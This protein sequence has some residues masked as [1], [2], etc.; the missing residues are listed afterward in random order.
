MRH[1][2]GLG[3]HCGLRGRAAARRT[4]VP[5]S[6]TRTG[7]RVDQGYGLTEAAGV[8]TTV[9]GEVLGHG[10][11]GRPLPGVEVR[12]GTEGD[13]DEPAEIFAARGQPLLR[14]LARRLRWPGRRRVVRHRRHR[15]SELRRAVPGRPRPGADH[16]QRLPRLP[17]RGGGGDCR[18]ARGRVGGRT[19][20]A[21]PAY[22]GAGDGLRHRRRTDRGRGRGA[23]RRSG[24]PSSS[25]PATIA[26]VDA[27][28]RG[29]TGQVQKGHS[30]AAPKTGH[31][32][33][34]MGA[35]TCR[36]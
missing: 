16:R 1:P 33:Q 10:H 6:P 11:V 35:E 8:S 20:P 17:G 36:L 25:V 23:L 26:V 4:C 34:R 3:D 14:L 29:A 27:L 9:G 24:W 22:G 30:G 18:A 5:S 2:S 13:A 32:R 15:L 28:P 19:R 12:I 21:G 7:L 31:R